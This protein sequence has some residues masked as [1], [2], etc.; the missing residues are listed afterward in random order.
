MGFTQKALDYLSEP[1]LIPTFPEEILYT[2]CRHAPDAALAI[3]Y[4]QTVSPVLTSGKVLETYF[5][6]LCRISVT[7]AFYFSRSQ[8]DLNHRILFEKLLKFVHANPDGA[9]KATRGVELISLPLNEEEEAW[10]TE[11]LEYG[12]ER[13]LSGANDTLVMRAIA[14]GRLESMPQD[15][16]TANSRNIDGINW[17]TLRGGMRYS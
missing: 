6:T 17:A 4:Y 3:A 16:K 10:F 8:G 5:L 12:K 11:V 15:R 9:L 1:A 13:D 7:E 14:V 2:L